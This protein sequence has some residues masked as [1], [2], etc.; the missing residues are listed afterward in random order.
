VIA[1]SLADHH[2]VVRQSLAFLIDQQPDMR[3]VAQAGSLAQAWAV[4]AGTGAHV[5]VVSLALPAGDPIDLIRD[6]RRTAP[7]TAVLALSGSA[8][9]TDVAWAIEAGAAGVCLMT[10]PVA[11]VLAAIRRLRAGAELLPPGEVVDLLRLAGQQRERDWVAQGRLSQLTRRERAVLSLLAEG[12]PDEEIA[13]RL[14]LSPETV[15]CHM[16]RIRKKLGVASRLQAL[17]FALRHGAIT[18]DQLP[19]TTHHHSVNRGTTIARPSP[20]TRSGV[21]AAVPASG[22]GRA[23]ALESAA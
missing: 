3:V 20:W 12:L 7:G 5:A 13:E 15:R 14:H 21:A 1:V 6:L 22:R 18:L 17:L 19:A 8:R 16:V 2:A 10:E 9:R 4:L 23:R 11:A